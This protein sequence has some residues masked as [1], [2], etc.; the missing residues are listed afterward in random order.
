VSREGPVA[1]CVREALRR[2]GRG[3]VVSLTHAMAMS[4]GPEVRVNCV[5]PAGST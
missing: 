3:G 1:Q 4:L 5:S 2:F